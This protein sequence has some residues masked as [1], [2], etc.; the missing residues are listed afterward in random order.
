VKYTVVMR[1][2]FA[3][4]GDRFSEREERRGREKSASE[5]EGAVEKKAFKADGL[6]GK[7]EVNGV[8][9]GNI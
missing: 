1:P 8:Q 9:V 3:L 7:D 4:F 6:E 2:H 5:R